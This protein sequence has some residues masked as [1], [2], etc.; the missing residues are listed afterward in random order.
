[1]AM[2]TFSIFNVGAGK[3]K[4][5]IDSWKHE[6]LSVLEIGPREQ[7]FRDL[8]CFTLD[9]V[10]CT[11]GTE[12]VPYA[13]FVDIAIIKGGSN[14][15]KKDTVGFQFA[16]QVNNIVYM[17]RSYEYHDHGTMHLEDINKRWIES[18]DVTVRITLRMANKR[19][20]DFEFNLK[21]YLDS[22]Y[23]KTVS[24]LDFFKKDFVL[25]LKT[26]KLHSS[27]GYD[28]FQQVFEDQNIY[29]DDFFSSKSLFPNFSPEI[30][31]MLNDTIMD[32]RFRKLGISE[33]LMCVGDVE[34][35]YVN[36]FYD[37]LFDKMKYDM[38]ED[39][40]IKARINFDLWF[41]MAKKLKVPSDLLKSMQFYKSSKIPACVENLSKEISPDDRRGFSEM[42]FMAICGIKSEVRGIMWETL[43]NIHSQYKLKLKLDRYS[44]LVVDQLYGL[45]NK[46]N[47]FGI[48]CLFRN[49]QRIITHLMTI[50][51]GMCIGHHSTLPMMA[52]EVRLVVLMLHEFF[53]KDHFQVCVRAILVLGSL[54]HETPEDQE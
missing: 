53:N 29:I 50:I 25:V 27:P 51:E 22:F 12:H 18:D 43:V 33:D 42:V 21:R 48:E 19:Y 7:H 38:I 14:L 54:M 32:G 49:H 2:G 46:K 17:E 16:K 9:K 31:N 44:P 37:M 13:V 15:L 47:K 20:E 35:G 40:F 52:Q 24:Y 8:P 26:L 1:M 3:F 34:D 45:M 41:D 30:L 10:I 4:R 11:L 5:T 6:D 36:Q 28:E 23:V 39:N